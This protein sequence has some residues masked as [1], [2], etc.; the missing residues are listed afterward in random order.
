MPVSGIPARIKDNSKN[1]NVDIIEA[2]KLLAKD[3]RPNYRGLQIPVK[4]SL[5]HEKFATYLKSYWDWQLPLFI[6]FGF[7]HVSTVSS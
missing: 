3:G 7:P 2:H 6:K 4:S 1:E 5:N